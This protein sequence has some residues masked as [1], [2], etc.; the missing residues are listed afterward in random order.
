[1]PCCY[2]SVCRLAQDM[3]PGSVCLLAHVITIQQMLTPPWLSHSSAIFQV[4]GLWIPKNNRKKHMIQNCI[5]LQKAKKLKGKIGSK[6][7]NNCQKSSTK[8]VIL[9]IYRWGKVRLS[10]ILCL[11]DRSGWEGRK[12]LAW[13][14]YLWP[15]TEW[16]DWPPQIVMLTWLSGHIVIPINNRGK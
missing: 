4:S 10:G 15:G 5:A 12:E 3:W 11:E 13:K 1:M 9:F 8:N 7:L 14:I 16:L 2:S 6:I